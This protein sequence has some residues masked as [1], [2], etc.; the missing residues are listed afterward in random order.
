MVG[1][2]QRL[3]G[4]EFEEVLG[5]S[6]SQVSLLCCKGLQRVGHD[7]ATE[8]QLCRSYNSHFSL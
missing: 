7:V 8:Q 3:N 1:W 6:E 4:H 2:H 5:D